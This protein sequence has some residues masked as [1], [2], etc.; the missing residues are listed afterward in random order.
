MVS[1]KERA[2]DLDHSRSATPD[3]FYK[4]NL[5]HELKLPTSDEENNSG[6]SVPDANASSSAGSQFQ[7]FDFGFDFLQDHQAPRAP[8]NSEWNL[9]MD[10]IA[11]ACLIDVAGVSIETHVCAKAKM[12]QALSFIK[13][14]TVLQMPEMFH[15]LLSL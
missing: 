2:S 11:S 13:T 12:V 8:S 3:I 6:S 15:P 9:S 5:P 4:A 7:A 1:G 14:R 10:H